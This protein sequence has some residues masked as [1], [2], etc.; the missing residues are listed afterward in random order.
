MNV[1]QPKSMAHD[2]AR[3]SLGHRRLV[4]R[5]MKNKTQLGWTA[6]SMRRVENAE[7]ARLARQEPAIPPA[8]V[9]VVTATYRR[10]ELLVRAVRSALAQTMTDIA[11]F[12][13]DDGGGL[14]SLPA[15]PRLHAYSLSA[16]TAVLSVVL[17]VGIRLS[18]SQY[19]AFLDD[20]NEWEPNHLEMALATLE[21]GPEGERPDVVYTAL[22]R[23]FPDGR[24]MDVLSVEFDRRTL[25]HDNYVDT[26]SLVIR[27]FPG[28]HFSRLK[29]PRGVRPKE[30]WELVYRMSRRLRIAHVPVQTVLYRVNPESYWTNWAGV[31]PGDPPPP[32]QGSS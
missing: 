13:I 4:V 30:D 10:P 18:N 25:A 22:K 12:V 6:V 27:R 11:V 2:L 20:D 21:A 29:R 23:C 9:A 28:L 1:F 32:P 24:L 3:R 7:V 17:N 26:N 5:E 19:V 14:P 16:N 31:A 8:R 15:D